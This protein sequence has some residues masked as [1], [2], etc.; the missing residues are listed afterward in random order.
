[1]AFLEGRRGPGCRSVG[2]LRRALGG[3]HAGPPV[4][5]ARHP[6]AGQLWAGKCPHQATDVERDCYQL[7]ASR[8]PIAA[9]WPQ[10]R[11][12]GAGLC[13]LRALSCPP[14]P[15]RALYKGEVGRRAVSRGQLKRTDSRPLTC[16]DTQKRSARADLL[17]VGDTGIEPVTFPVS[18]GRAPAAPIARVQLT[19]PCPAVT[20]RDVTWSPVG[21][22]SRWR[23]DLNP[24]SRICSPVPRLSAT[25]PSTPSGDRFVSTAER[26]TGFEPATL[27]LAR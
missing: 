27:T 17:R 9:A 14:C 16:G 22:R 18:G 12:I 8:T 10:S 11:A 15:L 6:P 13:P 21:T 26:T 25:P 23:R 20:C 1:M 5:G 2:Q 19:L 3:G 7:D 24:C 4:V